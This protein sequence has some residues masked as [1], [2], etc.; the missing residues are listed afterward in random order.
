MFN[1]FQRFLTNFNDIQRILFI[2]NGFQR[3]LT[4]FMIFYDFFTNVFD[5]FVDSERSTVNQTLHVL[6]YDIN[7]EFPGCYAR[8]NRDLDVILIKSEFL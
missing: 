2:Y 6:R 4:I 7:L 8:F 5:V 1:D 3:F